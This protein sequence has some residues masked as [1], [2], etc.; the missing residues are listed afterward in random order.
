M[1]GDSGRLPCRAAPAMTASPVSGTGGQQGADIIVRVCVSE[2]QASRVEE[3][4]AIDERKG[5]LDHRFYGYQ[6]AGR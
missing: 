3:V 1:Q 4:L 6:R 2:G 5:P